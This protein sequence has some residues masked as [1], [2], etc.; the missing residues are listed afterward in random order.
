MFKESLPSEMLSMT[1]TRYWTIEVVFND[2]RSYDS[3]FLECKVT[4][5]SVISNFFDNVPF[6]SIYIL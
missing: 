6:F 4:S 2:F 3:I 5:D 1:G